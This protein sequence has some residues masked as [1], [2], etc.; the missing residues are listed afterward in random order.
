MEE[1]D[2]VRSID[3]QIKVHREIVPITNAEKEK[4]KEEEFLKKLDHDN[5]LTFTQFDIDWK[6][7][8]KIIP[9]K[10]RFDSNLIKLDMVPEI[11]KPQ[12]E[13]HLA[14]CIWGNLQWETPELIKIN[15]IKS[16]KECFNDEIQDVHIFKTGHVHEPF[17]CVITN[18]NTGEPI[19]WIKFL[20][21]ILDDKVWKEYI[22]SRGGADSVVMPESVDD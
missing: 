6:V 21:I 7:D 4:Q 1:E 19:T 15:L 18:K 22:E 2:N 9:T 8:S 17:S 16:V 13:F 14:R 10:I 12:A 20:T 11:L 3:S 5:K